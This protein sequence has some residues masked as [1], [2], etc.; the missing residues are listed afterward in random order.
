MRNAAEYVSMPQVRA[1]ILFTYS[2]HC[3]GKNLGYQK[4][5]DQMVFHQGLKQVVGGFLPTCC[6]FAHP[7]GCLRIM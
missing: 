4:Q 7:S 1:Y 5:Q 2:R 6:L 3:G